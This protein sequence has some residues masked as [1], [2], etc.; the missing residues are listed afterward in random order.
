MEEEMA[1]LVRQQNT[2]VEVRRIHREAEA[3][4]IITESRGFRMPG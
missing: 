2:L 3:R 1:E 4:R